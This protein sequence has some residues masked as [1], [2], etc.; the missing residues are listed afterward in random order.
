MPRLPQARRLPAVRSERPGED[1]IGRSEDVP[2]LRSIACR[3]MGRRADRSDAVGTAKTEK[4]PIRNTNVRSQHRPHRFATEQDTDAVRA[5]VARNDVPS[6]H[7]SML[8]GEPMVSCPWHCRSATGE[9]S[10]RTPRERAIS[11]RTSATER[12]DLGRLGDAIDERAA[13][14]SAAGVAIARRWW[15]PI[16][17]TASAWKHDPV[18]AHAL[19][20]RV[21]KRSRRSDQHGG[22]CPQLRMCP[23]PPRHG[24]SESLGREAPWRDRSRASRTAAEVATASATIRQAGGTLTVAMRIFP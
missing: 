21:Q 18:L 13:R 24:Q 17:R 8:I 7:G 5:L 9:S 10:P 6:L 1:G 12:S 14:W 2:I 15:K 11:S 23:A 19:S 3:P 4:I 16:P 22:A 20:L